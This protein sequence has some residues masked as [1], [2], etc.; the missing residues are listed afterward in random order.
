MC[1]SMWLV[2][3]IFELQLVLLGY[4]GEI[5]GFLDGTQQEE[6]AALL[7]QMEHCFF[8][9]W[10]R[11][12]LKGMEKLLQAYLSSAPRTNRKV[13][14]FCN[15]W[16]LG[17]APASSNKR[18]S[19]SEKAAF[20]LGCSPKWFSGKS[21]RRNLASEVHFT[22]WAR[23]FKTTNMSYW[24]MAPNWKLILK[25]SFSF[26]TLSWWQMERGKDTGEITYN[27]LNPF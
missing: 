12:N 19:R 21:E 1:V 4:E 20:L 25:W 3:A 15:K 22:L 5:A 2:I 14:S 9:C 8:K 26:W 16:T 27:N 13:D 23:D 7:E 6:A 17:F 11:K 18:V 10:W 24:F